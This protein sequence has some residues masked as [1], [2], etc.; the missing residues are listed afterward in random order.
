M[1]QQEAAA[2]ATRHAQALAGKEGELRAKDAEGKVSMY[3]YNKFI[4]VYNVCIHMRGRCGRGVW[5]VGWVVVGGFRVGGVGGAS[6]ACQ[7]YPPPVHNDN[8]STNQPTHA[9]PHPTTTT[10]GGGPLGGAVSGAGGGGGAGPAGARVAGPGRGAGAAEGRWVRW[11]GSKWM[12]RIL[13]KG[14]GVGMVSRR[15]HDVGSQ[16]CIIHYNHYYFYRRRR[17]ASCT[18]ASWRRCVRR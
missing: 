14:V 9:R 17:P 4:H 8:Q 16:L 3:T 10:G 13:G 1:L 7:S 11:L 5:R 2:A 12:G 6:P 15:A 18:R